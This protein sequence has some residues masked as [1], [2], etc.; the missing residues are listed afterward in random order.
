MI[1]VSAS[2]KRV[3]LLRRCERAWAEPERAVGKGPDVAVDVRV[4]SAGRAGRRSR[5]WCRESRR[6]PGGE[7]A[8]SGT[9][10][11][12]A[13]TCVDGSHRP[14]TCQPGPGRL[15]PVD[16]VLEQATS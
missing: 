10:S 4:R 15:D 12:R 14:A 5:S 9:I 7:D 2:M 3:D 16:D 6:G 13:P 11:E 8:R 1:S